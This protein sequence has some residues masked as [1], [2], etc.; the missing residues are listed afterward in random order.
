M[1]LMSR[2]LHRVLVALLFFLPIIFVALEALAQVATSTVAEPTSQELFAASEKVY[3]DWVSAG[4]LAG[5][6]AA[7]KLFVDVTKL[8]VVDKWLWDHQ[9]R[10]VRPVVALLLGGMIQLSAAIPLKG[11][12]F[13]AFFYGVL[14]G[15]SSIGV[16]E[17]MIMASAVRATKEEE[18]PAIAEFKEAKAA[19]KAAKEDTK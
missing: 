4:A 2:K 10:W 6:I 14:A 12:L 15:A 11:N 5:V 9:W 16:N 7:V 17:L 3:H 18:A 8:K 13:I 19:A 1:G